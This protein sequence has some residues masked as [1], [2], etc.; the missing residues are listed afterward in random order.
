MFLKFLSLL[1]LIKILHGQAYFQFNCHPDYGPYEPWDGDP[2][3]NPC[4]PDQVN[5]LRPLAKKKLPREFRFYRI[6]LT[7]TPMLASPQTGSRWS[8]TKDSKF[9]RGAVRETENVCLY[10]WT[11]LHLAIDFDAE[12]LET[13]KDVQ[14]LKTEY[15]NL[16]KEQMEVLDVILKEREDRK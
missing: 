1:L 8:F 11:N 10:K 13:R 5:L 2:E 14:V 4:I 15:S 12:L 7:T 3:E 9:R 16:R 6:K